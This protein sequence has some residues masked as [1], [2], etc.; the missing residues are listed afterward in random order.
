[1]TGIALGSNQYQPWLVEWLETETESGSGSRVGSTTAF[2]KLFSDEDGHG[3]DMHLTSFRLVPTLVGGV[4]G[5]GN[6]NDIRVGFEG[7]GR[8]G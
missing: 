4:A 5:N 7:S 6:G 8:S 3:D 2:R 1:M